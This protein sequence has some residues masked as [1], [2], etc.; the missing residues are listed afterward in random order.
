MAQERG[1]SCRSVFPVL[2]RNFAIF[3]GQDHYKHPRLRCLSAGWVSAPC[4]QGRSYKI[5]RAPDTPHSR[6]RQN[7][8][9]YAGYWL[10]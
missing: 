9:S 8:A 3:L 7:H 10:E 2:H 1:F 4:I 6:M 5:F